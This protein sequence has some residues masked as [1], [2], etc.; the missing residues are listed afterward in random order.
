[1]HHHDDDDDDHHHHRRH[2]R[3]RRRCFAIAFS[4]RTFQTCYH[5]QG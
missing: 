5:T 3:H 2:R 4:A 1:M